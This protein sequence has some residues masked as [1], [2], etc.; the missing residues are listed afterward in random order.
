MIEIV[1]M[2]LNYAFCTKMVSGDARKRHGKN[3]Y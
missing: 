2:H 1:R 3:V